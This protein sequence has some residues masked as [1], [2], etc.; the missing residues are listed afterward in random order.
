MLL[1][2][3]GASALKVYAILSVNYAI[4]KA[5]RGSKAGPVLTW[6]FNALVLYANEKNSGHR[7]EQL[8]PVFASLV[9]PSDARLNLADLTSVRAGRMARDI[10]AVVH[11][12]QHHYAAPRVLQYGLLLGV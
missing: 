5:C 1:G 3:H 4:A 2:L 9:R 10:S 11:Q 12:L 6:I 8:H 7:F